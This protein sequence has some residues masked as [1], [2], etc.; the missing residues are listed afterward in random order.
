MNL[1]VR[2]FAPS[3]E[4]EDAINQ[5]NGLINNLDPFK[6]SLSNDARKKMRVV[7]SSRLGLVDI[8]SRLAT[9]YDEKLAKND[10]AKDLKER[11]AYLQV[12]RAYRIAAQKLC[13]AL[14]DTD[15]ALG[16]DI[17]GYVDKFGDSLQSARKYDGDLDEAIKELDDY[18]A[19][20]K[21]VMEEEDPELEAGEPGSELPQ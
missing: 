17:M 21:K 5:I 3:D 13:E 10:N 16:K 9:Q 14:D 8:V 11:V 12:L 1:M 18:N 6:V 4:L 7:G 20:F 19:R 15:K 2:S